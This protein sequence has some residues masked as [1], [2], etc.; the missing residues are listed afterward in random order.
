MMPLRCAPTF[1][2]ETL[3][4]L[5]DAGNRGTEGVVLW[6]AK[7]PLIEGAAIAETFIPQYYA[8]IDV[9]RIPPSGMAALMTHL[10]THRLAL[11]A[12]VHSHPGRA[13]HS[14][15]DDAWAIVRHE[16]ALSVVV[17]DFAAGVSTANFLEKCPTFRLSSTDRWLLVRP[18]EL[19][20]HLAV[21]P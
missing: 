15:A 10:R 14:P 2:E 19:P 7:R 3:A 5:R 6:L 1:V 16:G 21:T 13:F 18:E 9:F 8:E 11:A 12:Q 20:R 4:S 17:P